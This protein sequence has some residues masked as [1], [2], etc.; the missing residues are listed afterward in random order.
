M[1]DLLSVMVLKALVSASPIFRQRLSKNKP[2]EN[3]YPHRDASITL[4]ILLEGLH[5]YQ[6]HLPLLVD[7]P[8][9]S[10]TSVLQR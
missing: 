9:L 7:N 8:H 1:G 2:G 4:V 5:V 10:F 6:I 3:V